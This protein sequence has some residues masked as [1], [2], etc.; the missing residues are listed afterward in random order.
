VNTSSLILR[1]RITA[2]DTRP[3]EP[4]IMPSTLAEL[5]VGPLAAATGGEQA[6]HR[7]HV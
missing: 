1:G 7:A 3:T 6:A 2:S 4:L 5:L